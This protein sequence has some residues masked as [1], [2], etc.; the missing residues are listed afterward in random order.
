MV[1]PGE[2]EG[3]RLIGDPALDARYANTRIVADAALEE[4]VVT[5]NAETL[6]LLGEVAPDDLPEARRAARRIS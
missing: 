6:N 3:Y 2:G 5:L 4:G 1:L